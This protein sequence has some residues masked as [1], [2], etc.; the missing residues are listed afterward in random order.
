MGIGGGVFFGYREEAPVAPG[1]KQSLRLPSPN[2]S[3]PQTSILEIERLKT[4]T[5]IYRSFRGSATDDYPDDLTQVGFATR[6]LIISVR[7]GR[8]EIQYSF[9]GTAIQEENELRDHHRVIQSIRAFRVR[10]AIAG[11]IA[12]YQLVA[13]L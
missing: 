2:I 1:G 13:M 4:P 10:N 11:Y 3:P 7:E 6:I 12:Q 8:L 5:Y 9:D